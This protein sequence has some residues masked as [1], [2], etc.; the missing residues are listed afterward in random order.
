MVRRRAWLTP[1]AF[2]GGV[3]ICRPLVVPLPLLPY[4][5]GALALLTEAHNW[6]Q[7]G[8][9]T[10]EEAAEL[11]TVVFASWTGDCNEGG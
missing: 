5:G 2:E 7:S 3:E 8:T 11:M 6:E 4:V 9:M 10:R 1:D